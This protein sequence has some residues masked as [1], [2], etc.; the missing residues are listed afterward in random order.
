MK[1]YLASP[2]FNKFEKVNMERVLKVLRA[3]G[4]DVFAPYEMVIKDAWSMPNHVWGEKVFEADIEHLKEAD[5]VIAINYGLYSD[6]GTA[7]EIGLAY[8]LGKTIYTVNFEGFTD[9]LM[10][11]NAN[12]KGMISFDYFMDNDR[13]NLANFDYSKVFNEQK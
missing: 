2:F 10:I 3:S 5:V 12:L 11:N 1:I 8:G 7:F 13:I 9:S 6:S 4:Y